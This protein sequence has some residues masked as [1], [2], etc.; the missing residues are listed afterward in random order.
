LPDIKTIENE[1]HTRLAELHG[2]IEP[3]RVEAEQLRKLTA[4]FHGSGTPPPVAPV[5]EQARGRTRTTP[6]GAKR[7]SRPAR[8]AATAQRAKRGRPPG[9]GDRVAQ[10]VAQITGQPGI[11]V[12]E[13]AA[14]IGTAP[15]Y[16]YRVLPRLQRD[17]R[18]TKRGKGYHAA[19]AAE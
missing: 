19:G 9:N 1:I 17:G 8:P 7:V 3:L 5:T 13:L 11:T 2:L 12:A 4:L 10:A 14:A 6:A 15:N 18:I 16:L